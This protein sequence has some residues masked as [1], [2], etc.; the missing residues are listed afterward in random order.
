MV[1]KNKGRDVAFSDLRARLEEYA[2]GKD[3]QAGWYATGETEGKKEILD[4]YPFSALRQM[5]SYLLLKTGLVALLISFVFLLSLLKMPFALAVLSNINRLT[6]TEADF[7]GWGREVM[8][9][10][11]YLW[12]G[13]VEDGLEAVFAP[14]TKGQRETE[15]EGAG[16]TGGFVLPGEGRIIRGFGLYEEAAGETRMSYGLLLE[17]PPRSPVYAAAAG[18][19]KRIEPDL[20]GGYI[21]VL[22]HGEEM[23]TDYAYLQEVL[24]KVGERVE[25][26][27]AIARAGSAGAQGGA[28][29]YFELREGG[30]PVDPVP[31]F[32]NR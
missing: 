6:T 7:V 14:G 4:F 8:P 28:I 13:S 2:A 26:G 5:H 11:R 24:V 29:L 20:Y 18:L 12:M 17:V 19:V 25:Q 32:V 23:E 31:L 22:A 16:E 15:G 27:Q 30:R 3:R 1:Y 21:M 9:A 10:L